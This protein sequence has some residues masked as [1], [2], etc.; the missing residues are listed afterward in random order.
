MKNFELHDFGMNDYT[1]QSD[2]MFQLGLILMNICHWVFFLT[3][4]L[5]KN[6]YVSL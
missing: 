2:N 6:K 4:C 1:L 5:I 3:L